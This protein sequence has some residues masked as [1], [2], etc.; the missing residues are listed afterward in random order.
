LSGLVSRDCRPP[1]ARHPHRRIVRRRPLNRLED[2]MATT[3]DALSSTKFSS[4]SYTGGSVP[5][6]FDI[7]LYRA[8]GG[9]QQLKLTIK[10]RIN[11][12]R[13]EK[14]IPLQL[15]Y[16]KNVFLTSRWTDA[17]W[18][19][20]VSAAAAQADMWN[21][22]FWL[23]P[24]PTFSGFDEVYQKDPMFNTFPNKAFRPNIR[25]ALEVDFAPT[26]S[27]HR[28]I[29]VANLNRNFVTAS[30][31]PLN[32]GAFRSDALLY[33]SLDAVPWV[34]PWGA[35]PGQPA[36]HYVIAHEIG[37]AIGLDHIGVILKAPLCEV[38]S[39]L[40]SA[41][42]D[43]FLPNWSPLKGGTGAQVCYGFG[44]APTMADNIMGA[45]DKFT[46]ENARPWNWA[47]YMLI[48]KMLGGRPL[49]ELALWRVVT[50]DPGPGKWIDNG[51]DIK[52]A[53]LKPV[54]VTVNDD[55]LIMISGNVLFDVNKS[56]IKADANAAL[57]TAAAAIKAKTGPRLRYVLINGHT[58]ATGPTDFNQRLSDLR[59]KAVAD[60][61]FARKYLDESK[62]RTQG[63]GKTRPIAPNT[64]APNRA[65]NR[66]VEIHLVNG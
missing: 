58:D 43:R 66:R 44:Q 21:N 64:D 5:T 45:G 37:H 30:G 39:A 59:A 12:R 6:A 31:R 3:Y 24:P 4:N 28:T 60:W 48:D 62:T 50:R 56:D 34:F 63:F 26:S 52:G 51:F 23:L 15:D 1:V 25:C 22:K 32:P 20:F 57:E 27:A 13:L 14:M 55:S 8:H 29:E 65:K 61:F 49:P 40:Q 11:L 54:R 7:A 41:N 47:L 38:A 19:G 16:D 36:T 2:L 10:L 35:G 53:D 46:V 33:D 9:F 18:T 42:A 17:D